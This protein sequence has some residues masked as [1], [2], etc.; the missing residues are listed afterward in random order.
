VREIVAQEHDAV[1]VVDDAVGGAHVG[2]GAAVLG[3][4]DVLHVPDLGQVARAPIERFGRN[5]QPGRIHHRKLRRHWQ[6]GEA[7]RRGGAAQVRVLGGAA[8]VRA[9]GGAAHVRARGGG[10]HISSRAINIDAD[11]IDRAADR[12]AADVALTAEPTIAFRMEFSE[13]NNSEISDLEPTA[14]APLQ[15]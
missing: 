9:R 10:A 7:P 14:T 11:E 8:H 13:K 2:R 5:A 3:D 6:R 12:R 4:V 15:G 1:G